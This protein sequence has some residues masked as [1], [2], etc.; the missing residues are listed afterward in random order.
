MAV[1]TIQSWCCLPRLWWRYDVEVSGFPSS[2]CGHLVLLRLKQNGFPGAATIDDWSS[3]NLPIL[4]WAKSQG[5]LT[6]YAH[7]GHGLV[8]NN[9]ELPL[10]DAA[11]RQRGRE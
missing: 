10:V 2:H 9:T 6:G 8:V 11:V 7:V 5:A 4:R 1:Q 3:W